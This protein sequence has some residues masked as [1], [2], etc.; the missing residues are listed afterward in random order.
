MTSFRVIDP[1][2]CPSVPWG[3]GG[4]SSR[5]LLGEYDTGGPAGQR[6]L[7]WR[8][9]TTEIL[10]SCP[11]SD[12][13][14]HSRCITLLSEDGFDLDFGTA[15]P[16]LHA[17]RYEP[18]PFSGGWPAYCHLQGRPAFVLNVMTLEERA[19]CDTRR[20]PL[21]D[22][23]TWSCPTDPAVIY[24]ASGSFTVTAQ[25]APATRLVAG[26]ALLVTDGMGIDLK[27]DAEGRAANALAIAVHK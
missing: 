10:A 8:V 3:N 21:E 2:N 22:V 15:A 13:A 11:F 4:G 26:Q 23:A 19:R 7:L 24:C 18:R 16:R 6:Q 17:E 9:S 25:A 1:D 12:Y 27:L 20:L 5:E 14:G